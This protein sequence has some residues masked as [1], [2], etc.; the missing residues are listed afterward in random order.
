[1]ADNGNIY[2]VIVTNSSGSDTGKATLEVVAGSLVGS[3]QGM[4]HYYKLEESAPPY[5]D[6]FGFTDATS[7]ATPSQVTGIVGNAQN[8]SGAEK[9]DIPD[10]N[11][12]DWEP[13]ESFSLEFWMKTTATPPDLN[14]AIGRND[15]STNLQWWVG[16]NPDGKASF[17]LIDMNND[18]VLIGDKGPVV[19]D[20]S[21]HLVA[22]VR[23][24]SLGKN[25]LYIDGSKVDSAD[26]AYS[27]TFEGSVAVNIGYL[28]LAPYYYFN[29]NLDEVAMYNVA[30]SQ[31]AIQEHYDNGQ[32]GHGYNK[33][34]SAPTNLVAIK[35]V[36][37]TTNVD[38]TWDDNSS[39]ELG[40][41]IQRAVGDSD[42]VTVYTN[43]DTVGADITAY[44]DTT[45]SD[46]TTY[47]YR[48][49]GYNSELVSD[50]SNKAEI[51]T[52]VPVELTSFTA[53]ISDGKVVLNWQTATEINN[54]GF[55]IQR[56]SDNIS[57]KEIA[58]IRGHGT[59]TDQSV[60]SYIDNSILSGKYYYRLKQV[61]FNGSFSYTS[62]IGVNI[63][64]PKNFSLD[65]NYPNPFNP[66][67][68]IRFA[69]PTNA[70]VSIKLYNTLGQEVV[71]IL[72]NEQL[73]A[74][75][76]EK[77]FNASSF[78]SGV[79]FYRLE[80]KGDDGS[81]FAKTKRLVLIK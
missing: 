5:I 70:K 81:S 40:F 11:V 13:N 20:G 28:N 16:F 17:Q 62:S 8:F 31:S 23:N 42:A 76:H 80:A 73:N 54:S 19:N 2:S 51:T 74:G 21:W 14:I 3:P 36:A 78:S 67:T 38:L 34:I 63:G 68:T 24:G 33:F 77:V 53:N 12:S 50:F 39:N 18:G 43:I 59:T 71:D 37:D 35:N 41:I 29:G 45:V 25:Y 32:V 58:F 75:V 47:T 57:F 79:Y 44:T 7:S 56:S 9:I 27:A 49:Y 69:L 64:I 72:N 46:T 10:D 60:Y 1:M 4:T 55:S 6:S 15:A 52:P 61:D 48:V 30:L 66:S 26:H 65:Q 22:A